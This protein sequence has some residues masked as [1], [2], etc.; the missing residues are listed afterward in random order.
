MHLID[1]VDRELLPIWRRSRG[2]FGP[3]HLPEAGGTM[4]QA[5]ATMASLDVMDAA[6]AA[7][8]EKP[9]SDGN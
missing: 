7:L 5:C 1:E 2:G 8:T 6:Y 3:G 4:D 9:D